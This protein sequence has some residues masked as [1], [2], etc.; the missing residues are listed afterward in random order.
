[1]PSQNESIIWHAKTTCL[2]S[3]LRNRRLK[4]RL[5]IEQ[6]MA[7][8]SKQRHTSLPFPVLITELCQRAG[9]PRDAARDFDVTLSSSTDIRHI[10]A[11]YTREEADRKR[12]SLVDTSPEVDIDSILAE[13]SSPTP[14]SEP[15]GTSAPSSSSQA[16]GT[17]TSSQ[18]TKITQAMI[19]KMGH[20]AHS[21]NVR[22]TRPERSIPWM[23]ESAILAALTPL[24]ISIDNLTMR[25]EAY[26]FDAPKT[27]EIPPATTGDVHTEVV[28]E[29]DAE[30]DEEHIKIRDERIYGDLPDLEKTIVQLMIQ[31]SLTETSMA[32]P[33]GAVP[34]EVTPGIGAQV[35]IDAPGTDAQTDGVIE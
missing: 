31:T 17:S 22:A 10:E 32:V 7:M 20:L 9:V 15:L 33:S 16:P 30:T 18:P 27:S 6:E 29:S 28:D 11:K 34:S 8:R 4:L 35:Q 24:Q 14:T 23:I 13:A 3:I 25:F 2:G 26:D 21:A 12:A 19:L 1:M 5:I